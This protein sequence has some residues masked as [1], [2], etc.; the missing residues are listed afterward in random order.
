[1][2]CE[3]QVFI[4]VKIAFHLTDHSNRICA[5]ASSSVQLGALF[6]SLK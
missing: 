3:L 4:R 6:A 5:V 2:G 1:M